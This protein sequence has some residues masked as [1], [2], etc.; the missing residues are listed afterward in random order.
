MS[1]FIA[2]CK[3]GTPELVTAFLNHPE[4]C[5]EVKF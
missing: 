1:P 2:A 5:L 4:T 3:N